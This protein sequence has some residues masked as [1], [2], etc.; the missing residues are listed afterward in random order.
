[1]R[2]SSLSRISVCREKMM[3][4]ALPPVGEDAA[5][6][7]RTRPRQLSRGKT[8]PA[9]AGQLPAATR[10]AA[11]STRWL[12][13]AGLLVVTGFALRNFVGEQAQ[14][15]AE[16]G[17]AQGPLRAA[18]A[19]PRGR[20]RKTTLTDFRPDI[21]NGGSSPDGTIHSRLDRR[22]FSSTKN[23]FPRSERNR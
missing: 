13:S 21:G 6:T 4:A 16:S 1:V 20:Q 2:S 9:R 18:P 3:E 5:R 17:R 12:V 22:R 14:K 15:S 11:S 23:T 10:R 7:R 8:M 19:A